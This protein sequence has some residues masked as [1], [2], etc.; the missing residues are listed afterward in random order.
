[1]AV[2]TTA[3]RDNRDFL[4][5]WTSETVSQFGS[6]ITLL[7]LPLTAVVLLNASAFEMGLLRAA[8]SAP[9]LLIG[10]LAG[11]WVDR[12]RR[13]PIL[14]ATNLGRALLLA[15][16]PLAALIGV[17]RIDL[18]YLVAFAAGTLTVFFDVA[19]VSFLPVLAH[20][21]HL[22]EGN[23]K[24]EMSRSFAQIAGPGAAGGLVQV[25]GAPFAIAVDAVSYVIAGLFVWR[26]RVEEPD[27]P[28]DRRAGVRAQLMEGLQTIVGSPVLRSI[29]ACTGTLN[30]FS[31]AVQA[32]FVLYLVR[33]LGIEPAM[34]GLLLMASGPGALIG[35]LLASRIADRI[36]VGPT[37]C[38]A[39]AVSIVPA[40]LIALADGPR[41]AVLMI[42]VVALFIQ[43]FLGTL[44]NVTQV[45]L[46][47]RMVPDHLQGRMNA[48]MRFVV[49][50]T[51]PL[52]SLAGGA[53]GEAI[54][55]RPVLIVDV[56]GVILAA[57]AVT[58]SP[59]RKLR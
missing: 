25:I 8:A 16:I 5:L 6:Q 35:A 12:H 32:V 48:S 34:T 51:L 24:L 18:L 26:I 36:G 45:S 39:A 21:E 38:G 2:Q 19:Y 23:S 33:D 22:V 28:T 55:L 1:M 56:L 37:I 17:V 11:V 29:A 54:G 40:T 9:F 44:Y 20:R 30:L 10:L 3:L 58:L 46:R 42:L 15:L 53:L 57:L 27:I 47:Q 14:L 7:A 43:A 31:G 4:K 41:S 50:G 49:W 52:G 59:V 13:R